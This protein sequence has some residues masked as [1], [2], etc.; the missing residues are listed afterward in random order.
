MERDDLLDLLLDLQHDLGKY[1]KLP[2]GM[3][4]GDADQSQLRAALGDALLHTQRGPR[5][6]VDARTLWERFMPELKAALSSEE[7]SPLSRAVER[8]LAWQA[9][10]Q[11]DRPL[12]R[13]AIWPD[14]TAVGQAI[15]ELLAE[16]RRGDG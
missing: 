16:V 8:A 3:L 7:L 5:G 11:D 9:R 14:L 13:E 10:L 6:A 4:P 1:L 12:S 15:D 2:L